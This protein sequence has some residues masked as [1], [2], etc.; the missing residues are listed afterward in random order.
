MCVTGAARSSF[1]AGPAPHTQASEA[2]TWLTGSSCLGTSTLVCKTIDLSPRRPT[3]SL[4][5]GALCGGAVRTARAVTSSLGKL[6]FGVATGLVA[7][8]V[9]SSGCGIAGQGVM[10]SLAFQTSGLRALDQSCHLQTLTLAL[11]PGSI[12]LT[13]PLQSCQDC[14]P[15]VNQVWGRGRRGY[16]ENILKRI[17][18]HTGMALNLSKAREIPGRSWGQCLLEL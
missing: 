3:G 4:L 17:H 7:V 15:L 18:Y 5:V 11:I 6:P 10:P 2:S 14:L 1:H 16:R 8:P 13:R 9:G 12:H